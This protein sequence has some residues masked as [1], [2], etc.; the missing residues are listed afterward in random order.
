[1]TR[2]S[3]RTPA[4][5]SG[6]DRTCYAVT[7]RVAA[8]QTGFEESPSVHGLSSAATTHS[9]AR[10]DL[11]IAGEPL[12]LPVAIA[13]R[14][15]AAAAIELARRSRP[16]LGPPRLRLFERPSRR[17][18]Q[19]AWRGIVRRWRDAWVRRLVVHIRVALIFASPSPASC[20]GD[21]KLCNSPRPP[22]RFVSWGQAD[23]SSP[24][25]PCI[26]FTRRNR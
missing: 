7:Y 15:E 18:R 12:H 6:S 11:K 4:L 1:M 9:Q 22:S 8:L 24:Q 17:W 13:H 26:I 10:F 14:I 20:R 2:Q 19:I 5:P 3:M 23:A 25:I 16:G 21:F